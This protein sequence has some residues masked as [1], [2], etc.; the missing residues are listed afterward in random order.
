[1]TNQEL[2]NLDINLHSLIGKGSQ[3]LRWA[4][5][6]TSNALEKEINIIVDYIETLKGDRL[7][8]L[9]EEHRKLMLSVKTEPARE[10]EYK[11]WA[12]REEY[13]REINA[14]E[15]T[16]EYKQFISTEN[17]AFQPY[18]ITLTPSDIEG[19]EFDNQKLF[20]LERIAKGVEEAIMGA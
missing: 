10:A 16:D 8:Q 3:R 13:E 4:V 18:E 11:K 20:V 19:I 2:L 15:N 14:F 17:T 7:K 6:R 12:L 1:M 9:Q 5:Y